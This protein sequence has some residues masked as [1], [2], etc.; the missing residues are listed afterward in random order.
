MRI[1][2]PNRSDESAMLAAW[3]HG[4][5]ADS[6]GATRVEMRVQPPPPRFSWITTMVINR[7]Q[8]LLGPAPETFLYTDYYEIEAFGNTYVV[9]FSTALLV[10]RELDRYGAR[11][12]IEF[13]DVFGARHRLP[14]RCVYRITESTRETRAALRAFEK[15]RRE[16]EKGDTDPFADLA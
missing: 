9:P 6:R 2:D 15:A 7:L 1:K 16:E 14:A 4:L 5:T 8:Y 10:E 3:I 12:W 13:R 11:G